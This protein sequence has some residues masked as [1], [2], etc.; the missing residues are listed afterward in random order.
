[1]LLPL[2][3]PVP[4]HDVVH[5]HA[6]RQSMSPLQLPAPSQLTVQR[7]SP[8]VTPSLHEPENVQRTSQGRSAGH[9][10][11]PLAVAGTVAVDDAGA[12]L[13]AAAHR[14]AVAAAVEL[15]G[16]DDAPAVDAVAALLALALAVAAAVV[17]RAWID[18]A[19]G[20]GDQQ[21]QDGRLHHRPITVTPAAS[22]PITG[23]TTGASSPRERACHHHNPP[24][25]SAMP[26]P[27]T[28]PL[29]MV[30]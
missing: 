30:A 4:S 16:I 20:E 28:R 23:V 9:T 17:A 24:A 10:T 27:I 3:A 15:V 11:G 26:P 14:R 8:Q 29:P 21:H 2:Q 5:A 18:A 12:A 22:G 25:A 1:M 7:A 6:L 13:A 19:A